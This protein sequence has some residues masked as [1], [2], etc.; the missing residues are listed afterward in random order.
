MSLALLMSAALLAQVPTPPN[1]FTLNDSYY[2][3]VTLTKTNPRTWAGVNVVTLP[4]NPCCAGPVTFA[5][6]YTLF[7]DT[8]SEWSL[9]MQYRTADFATHCPV[10][11]SPTDPTNAA[12]VSRVDLASGVR[13]V[14]FGVNGTAP[15]TQ[16][17]PAYRNVTLS[18]A[19][20]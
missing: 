5:L 14:T 2:G 18:L 9:T 6:H 13:K 10:A 19:I 15:G 4:A 20:P 11:S 1:S 8:A 12:Y 7:F 16:C 3:D 17:W